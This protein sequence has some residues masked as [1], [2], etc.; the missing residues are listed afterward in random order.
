[1]NFLRYAHWCMSIKISQLKDHSIPL[2]QDGYDTSVAAKYLETAT[3]KD[4][5][6]FHKTNLP[7]DII[8]IKEY[9]SIG[10]EK[11]E[12][13]YIEYNIHYQACVG[14]FIYI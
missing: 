2:D 3:I 14:S 13:L 12:V 9:A 6:K 4:N 5:S 7:H 1:M 8:F 11:V 10:D